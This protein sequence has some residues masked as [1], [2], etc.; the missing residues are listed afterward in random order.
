MIRVEFFSEDEGDELLAGVPAYFVVD[1]G[2]VRGIGETTTEW[3]TISSSAFGVTT[4]TSTSISCVTSIRW[5]CSP[6]DGPRICTP[7]VGPRK[8]TRTWASCL[9]TTRLDERKDLESC[10]TRTASSKPGC[11]RLDLNAPCRDAFGQYVENGTA[12]AQLKQDL[13]PPACLPLGQVQP[14]ASPPRE[15]RQPSP[16]GGC[17]AME[18]R[19][20][21]GLRCP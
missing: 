5:G 6:G 12:E 16:H 20:G 8:S 15:A 7:S 3:R 2:D 1:A 17:T 4:E 19:S 18:S 14:A 10:A 11:R 21:E 9:P 13:L